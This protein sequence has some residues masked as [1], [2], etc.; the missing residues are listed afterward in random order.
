MTRCAGERV[1]PP[2][3]LVRQDFRSRA[4]GGRVR[5]GPAAELI[6][7]DGVPLPA[8]APAYKH[9]YP[10]AVVTRG[11][12]GVSGT[13]TRITRTVDLAALAADAGV[14]AVRAVARGAAFDVRV[15]ADTGDEIAGP[16]RTG[17]DGEFVVGSAY[18]TARPGVRAWRPG[19]PPATP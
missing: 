15:L 12:D 18:G 8:K 10:H 5:V 4:G 9:E 13:H 17:G 7:T 6:T 14:A 3:P 19:P 11:V 2:T 1:E 16:E